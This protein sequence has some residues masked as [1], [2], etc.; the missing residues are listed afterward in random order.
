MLNIEDLRNLYG[1]DKVFFTAHVIQRC[2]Q[3][4]IKPHDIRNCIMGGEIIEQYPDDFPDP[5]CL[6]FGYTLKDKVLH[7][8]ISS[9]EE[10]AKIVTA[11]FPNSEK[12][13]DDMK[14]R[15]ERK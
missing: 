3:R 1:Q 8:V 2:K 4:D 6:V 12:F 9:N 13:E 10:S 5:S 14:T 15:K 11:Y 7:V